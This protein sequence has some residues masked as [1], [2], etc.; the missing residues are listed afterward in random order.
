MFRSALL[1]DH[2]VASVQT[3]SRFNPTVRTYI[4]RDYPNTTPSTKPHPS[5]N[6]E[7]REEKADDFDGLKG[8]TYEDTLKALM[9]QL[10]QTD[11]ETT[12]GDLDRHEGLD[13]VPVSGPSP[14]NRMN[15]P[16]LNLKRQK[17]KLTQDQFVDV[18]KSRKSAEALAE[19]HEVS[20]ALISQIKKTIGVKELTEYKD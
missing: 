3:R 12:P 2:R 18:V 19:E 8:A 1:C 10:S 15:L 14:T 13:A 9:G 7:P 5:Q 11:V 17:G 4:K 16:R 20:I 6:P